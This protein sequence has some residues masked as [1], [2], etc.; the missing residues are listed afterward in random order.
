MRLKNFETTINESIC[1]ELV[2]SKKKWFCMCIY[3]PPNCDNLLLFLTKI[4]L[5]L[6]KSAINFE[7]F[8][9]RGDF[10]ID[11]NASGRGK[12]KLDEFYNLFDLTNLITEITCCTNSHRSTIHLILTNKPD[13]FQKFCSNET[14]GSD[15]QV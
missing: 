1:S 6:N 8:I 5:S 10:N 13:S 2:I 4:T 3:R 15:Y 12:D 11:L 7:N 9:V 14:D